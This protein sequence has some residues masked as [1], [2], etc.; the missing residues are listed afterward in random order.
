[1][2]PWWLRKPLKMMKEMEDEDDED[3]F[4]SSWNSQISGSLWCFFWSDVCHP[5]TSKHRI[6]DGVKLEKCPIC[7]L[8]QSFR[9]VLETRLS[10]SPCSRV[11]VWKKPCTLPAFELKF[12]GLVMPR[13]FCSL[14]HE[15]DQTW[16]LQINVWMR[17][18][19]E[20]EMEEWEPFPAI[21]WVNCST[22]FTKPT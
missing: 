22:P 16:F 11:L 12:V 19:A 5:K 10:V 8:G 7:G 1:M 15:N 2:W 9:W 17:Q 14:A 18:G 13:F 3:K 4:Q 20:V 21:F 6:E